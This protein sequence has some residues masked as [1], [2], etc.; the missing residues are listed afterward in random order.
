MYFSFKDTQRLKVKRW[1]KIFFLSRT[2]KRVAIVSSAKTDKL[3]VFNKRLKRSL[4]TDN[5][6]SIQ[7]ECKNCKLYTHNIG[8]TKYTKQY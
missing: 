7:K 5:K 4:Y 2:Q 8:A 6:G 3:N 1:K